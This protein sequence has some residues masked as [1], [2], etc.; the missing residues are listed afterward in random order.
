MS[1]LFGSEWLTLA[2]IATIPT[3]GP[4]HAATKVAQLYFGPTTL[5]FAA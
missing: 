1:G 5:T 4:T 3:P 2:L